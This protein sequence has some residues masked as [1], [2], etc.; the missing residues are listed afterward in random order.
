MGLRFRGQPSVQDTKSLR[1]LESHYSSKRSKTQDIALPLRLETRSV[2]I[3]RA[4]LGL[5]RELIDRVLAG[6]R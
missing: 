1:P 6:L 4:N 5:A 2:P 3:L